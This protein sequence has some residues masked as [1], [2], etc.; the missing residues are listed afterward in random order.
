[1]SPITARVVVRAR[2]SPLFH[3]KKMQSGYVIGQP[4]SES[5]ALNQ[6]ECNARWE[7]LGKTRL[8]YNYQR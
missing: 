2:Q 5:N 1:M 3:Y 4:S 8:P 6:P 7:N